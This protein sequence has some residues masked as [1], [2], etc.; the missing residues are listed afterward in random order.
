MPTERH[1]FHLSSKIFLL[2]ADR[3][4]YSY[5][6]LGKIYWVPSP[7]SYIHSTVSTLKAQGTSREMGQGY[8]KSQ[9]TMTFDAR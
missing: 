5:R 3:D 2:A 9:K 7:T 4:C 6:L 1:R 8:F